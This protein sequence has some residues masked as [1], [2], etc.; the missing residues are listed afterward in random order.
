M[1]EETPGAFDAV[2]RFFSLDGDV[3]VL[4]VAM[5]AFSL[6]FQMT[7]RYIPEYMRVLGAGAGAI[8]LY[9]SIGTLIGAVYPYPGGALSDRIGSRTALTLFGVASTAGFV[10]WLFAETA[11]ILTV[12]GI[13][14]PVGAVPLIEA[15]SITL[16]P[17]SIPVGIVLGLFLTQAWKSFGLGATFAVV[18]QST[19]PDALATG[20]ASTETFR[21]VGFLVGPLLAAAVLAATAR[22]EIGFKIVLGIAALLAGVATVTQHRLYDATEDTIG[23]SF[24]G[25]GAVLTDLRE[26]PSPLRPL[27]VADALVRFANG[28]VYVFFV[29]VITNVLAVGLSVPTIEVFGASVGGFSLRPD[30]FFGILLAIE[31]LIALLTM[32]PAAKLARRVGL[33][34]VVALGFGVYAVFPVLLINAPANAVVVGVLF[35]FSGL[36]FAGLPA[37]KALIVG[38]ASADAGGRV[39]GSYYLVRDAV[40]IPSAAIGGWIYTIDP[41]LAFGVA[42]AIGLVGTLYFLAAG[43]EFEADA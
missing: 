34:P 30:A 24:S 40:R 3:L 28:M 19:A 17:V 26:M 20:F 43:Q 33:K 35:A 39:T 1:S 5:F 23:D 31:M 41:R 36:R 14:V 7:G 9:G 15:G 22:F 38:P 18:K 10:V 32:A 6:S 11:G 4:S 42:S 25:I 16:D 21:R 8:G 12:G 13:T 27:L 2:R 37:H 29:I